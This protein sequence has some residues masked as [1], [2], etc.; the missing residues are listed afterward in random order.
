MKPLAYVL[1]LL[2]IV[3]CNSSNKSGGSSKD[4][5]IG[6]KSELLVQDYL[7]RSKS[8]IEENYMRINRV[9]G[10]YA[11]E[12]MLDQL[13][14]SKVE[15]TPSQYSTHAFT[16]RGVAISPG[17]I[18]IDPAIYSAFTQAIKRNGRQQQLEAKYLM[19]ELIQLIGFDDSRYYFTRQILRRSRF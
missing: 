11:A 13:Q 17:L 2:A 3:A 12:S 14:A 18:M 1:L 9:L 5:P 19:H 6:T 15:V 10:P 4:G 7:N 16:E 8:L